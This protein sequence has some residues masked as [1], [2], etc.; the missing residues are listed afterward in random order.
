[1]GRALDAV[2]GAPFFYEFVHSS[3]VVDE[4]ADAAFVGDGVP[5]AQAAEE[6]LPLLILL[7]VVGQVESAGIPGGQHQPEHV[8][9]AVGLDLGT[10]TALVNG[11]AR[12]V[13]QFVRHDLPAAVGGRPA[14]QQLLGHGA[15][16]V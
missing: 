12:R 2:V 6:G 3:N 10:E 15:L 7:G 5:K 8:G 9:G 13:N 1:M 16:D 4:L 14:R 11:A